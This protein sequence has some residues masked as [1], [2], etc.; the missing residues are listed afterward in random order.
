MNASSA[1]ALFNTA[2]GGAGIAWGSAGILAVAYPDATQAAVRAALL[3]RAAAAVERQPSD[4][5]ARVIEAIAALFRGEKRDLHFAALDMTAVDAFS[6]GVYRETR[7]IA[8]GEVRT[9][10]EI[11]QALGGPLLAQR[12]GQ[13]L[14]SNPFPIIV[15]CH[16]VIGA[17]GRLVGFSAPGGVAAKRRLLAVEGALAPDLFDAAG[18]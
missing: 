7:K 15:P 9:Y 3:K 5:I 11:A 14:A 1:Y 17:D 4:E 16:R 6:A 12:V 10:G 13:A 8:P 2:F 18:L